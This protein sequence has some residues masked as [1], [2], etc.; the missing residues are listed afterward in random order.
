[1]SAPPRPRAA[2]RGFSLVEL[3]VAL[4]IGVVTVV[5][6]IALM[7]GVQRSFQTTGRDR[8][9]QETARV[10]LGHLTA[11][12]RAAGFGVDPALALDLGPLANARMDLAY[13][14]ATF[15]TAPTPSAAGACTALCRDSTAA[16]DELVFYARDPAFGPHP[17]TVAPSATSVTF[18]GTPG[19]PILAGQV[20]QVVCYS[21]A[22]TWTYV[23]AAGPARANGDG[24]FTV[25]LLSGTT[26]FPTQNAWLADACYGAV[27]TMAGGLPT[28]ASLRTAAEVFKVDR[29][30]YYVQSFDA[31][32]N[33][34]PWNA[35]NTR[36][37]LMLDQGTADGSGSTAS[38]VAP[39][40]EDL[41]VAYVF[42]RD[43][44][45]PLVGAAE[46]VAITN[47]DGG[48]NLGSPNG[49]PVFSDADGAAA[50]LDHHPGNVG[51]VRVS[52][53]VRSAVADPAVPDVAIPAAGNR[54]EIRGAAGYH[55]L[56]V[57]ATVPV[58]NLS[59]N[60]PYFPTWGASTAASGSRQSN[61][62]GG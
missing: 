22:M 9:L 39:D 4:G 28:D 13:G 23:T 1:M 36:P 60:A 15:P 37:F 44:A 14:A 5:A 33:V 61:V 17:L 32:G 41:Q 40:V 57:E 12:L 50:R 25:P 38:V 48:I 52:V 19:V 54:P 59:M 20:L 2:P 29:Y 43:P 26:T 35:A 3:V 8:T 62:G 46:G 42:P 18:G 24:T 55:R 34:Q 7:V 11:N 45:T 21:G 56:R 10:A 16:P 47:D 49:G 27:A 58:P 6:A 51:A 31:A 53:V 30:R